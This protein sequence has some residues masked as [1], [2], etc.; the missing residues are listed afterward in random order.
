MGGSFE[1]DNF[2]VFNIEMCFFSIFFFEIDDLELIFKFSD[3]DTRELF[4]FFDPLAVLI[5]KLF[6]VIVVF[7][8]EFKSFLFLFLPH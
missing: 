4:F 1:L 5:Q 8:F 6:M 3:V 2:W 7:D